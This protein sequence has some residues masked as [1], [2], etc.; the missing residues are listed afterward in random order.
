MRIFSNTCHQKA[1]RSFFIYNYQFP[2]CARCT[3]LLL[4]YFLGTIILFVGEISLKLSITFII[5]MFIDWFV[6][7]KG[8]KISNNYR[9]L[10]TGS[11]CGIGVMGILSWIYIYSCDIF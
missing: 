2:I 9:R 11:L 1:N 4:G 7:Y 6:Q 3:G 5:I 8:I 10:F